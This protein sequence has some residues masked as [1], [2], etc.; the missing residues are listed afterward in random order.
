[1]GNNNLKGNNNLIFPGDLTNEDNI[2]HLVESIST[3]DGL[4]MC[5]G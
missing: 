2:K 1:M 4:A 5:G 3:I